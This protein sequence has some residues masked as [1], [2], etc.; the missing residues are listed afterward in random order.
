MPTCPR[1]RRQGSTACPPHS[2]QPAAP[3]P[4]PPLPTHSDGDVL[5]HT[6]VDA[7]LGALCLPDIGQ[8]FPDNDPK[9]KGARR[10]EAA[11]C[12]A[13]WAHLELQR[14]APR[15]RHHCPTTRP[16]ELAFLASAPATGVW[17]ACSAHAS[18]LSLTGPS[19]AHPAATFS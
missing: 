3:P 16:S 10:W 17:P 5:L 1:C 19:P 4:P 6:V 7:I 12:I 8:L 13:C 14:L 2:R 15:F 11:P 18:R 9:W